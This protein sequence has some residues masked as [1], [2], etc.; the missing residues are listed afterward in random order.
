MY[1]YKIVLM[2]MSGQIC[3]HAKVCGLSVNLST[4]APISISGRIGY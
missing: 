1:E 4:K 2:C 3:A